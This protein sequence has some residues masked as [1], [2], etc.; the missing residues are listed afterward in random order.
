MGWSPKR[1]CPPSAPVFAGL[2][3]FDELVT[4]LGSRPWCPRLDGIDTQPE[5]LRGVIQLF[6]YVGTKR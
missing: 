6:G 4:A 1:S 5:P 3:L 2:A